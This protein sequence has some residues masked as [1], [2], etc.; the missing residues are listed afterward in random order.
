MTQKIAVVTGGTRGIG[1][2]IA[3]RLSQE[4]FVLTCSRS[5]STYQRNYACDVTSKEQVKAFAEDV[6]RRFGGI[7]ILVNNAGGC[8]QKE[9]SFSDLELNEADRVMALNTQS[10]LYVTH[11]FWK[12]LCPGSSIV[13]VSSTLARHRPLPGKMLYSVSKAALEVITKYQA[14]EG[15]PLGIRANCIMPGPVNT[16]LLR[17]HF[18]QDGEFKQ[19][20]FT[21]FTASLP[22]SRISSPE[23]IADVVYFACKSP[24]LTGQTISLD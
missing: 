15:A 8:A 18:F 3:E 7:D 14:S 24:G 11:A 12:L 9:Y 22:L 23:E 20:A 5:G 6:K 21:G 4:Y 16:D 1:K 17:S 10:V 2:A 13:N 19:D